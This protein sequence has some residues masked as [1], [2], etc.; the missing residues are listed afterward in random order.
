MKAS[1]AETA[2]KNLQLA[3]CVDASAIDAS[4]EAACCGT[5]GYRSCAGGEP[6][7]NCPINELLNP[8]APFSKPSVSLFETSCQSGMVGEAWTLSDAI[9]SCDALPVC[10]MTCGGPNKRTM[11]FVAN[12]CGCHAG[13]RAERGGGLKM[14]RNIYICDA[15]HYETNIFIIQRMGR[16]LFLN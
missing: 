5:A 15:S 4:F 8:P 6:V 16:S 1:H 2:S 7:G 9:Y 13:E 11:N 12:K 14:K 3:S 10:S